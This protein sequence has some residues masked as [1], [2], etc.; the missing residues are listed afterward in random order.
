M[1]PFSFAA[2]VANLLGVT[3]QVTGL[4]YGNWEYPTLVSAERLIYEL[5]QL[6]NALQSLEATA[7]SITD[8]VNPPPHDLLICLEGVKTRLTSLRSK[9]VRQGPENVDSSQ[10]LSPPP[11]RSFN[12]PMP[13][14]YSR[15]LLSPVEATN[16]IQS[17]QACLSNL[18]NRSLAID[19]VQEWQKD[20]RSLNVGL[21]YFYFSYKT[22][23]PLRNAALALLEQLNLQLPS[24][25]EDVEE[26]ERLAADEKYIAFP[27]IVSAVIAVS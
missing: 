20:N 1:D 21:A 7:L 18:D 12:A 6:R 8:A 16:D 2:A 13:S 9:L 11:W 27:D 4:L 25:D 3:I 17:L 22:P 10:D 5:S 14:Q 24:P 19:S 26:L 15:Q 23:T